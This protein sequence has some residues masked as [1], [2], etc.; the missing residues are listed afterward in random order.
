[1][2]YMLLWVVLIV[3]TIATIVQMNLHGN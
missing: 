2:L 1:M 3:M